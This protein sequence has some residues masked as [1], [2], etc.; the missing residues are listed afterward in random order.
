MSCGGTQDRI[1]HVIQSPGQERRVIWALWLAAA[2][3]AVGGLMPLAFGGTSSRITSAIIPFGIGA[4]ALA[5]CAVFHSQGRTPISV[6]YFVAGLAIV[7]GLL[8]IFSLPI[9]LAA[10]GT[11]PALPAPCSTGLPRPL[12]DG[13]NNGIGAAA[14]CGIAGLLLGFYGLVTAFRRPL[15]Q[16]ATPP[17]RR[18][19][20]MEKPA[21]VAAPPPPA[22]AEA[23]APPAP[24][25]PK[26][27][28][29]EPELPAHEE[30]E[31]PELPPH[32]STSATT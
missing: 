19:P 1:P 16:P 21:P 17:V 31:L 28:E 3:V 26:P 18:I 5:A 27:E 15:A 20:P 14:A 32:E 25:E 8:S 23:K 4:I 10:L 7:Y 2:V 6:I 9:R 11:C 29:E 22:P 30:E 13:E 12:T 24:V